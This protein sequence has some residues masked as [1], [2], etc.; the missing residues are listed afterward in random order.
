ME[1]HP[2]AV[3]KGV[4]LPGFAAPLA[5]VT[6]QRREA[7][8]AH[9]QGIAV[10]PDTA[11]SQPP[12]ASDIP[13]RSDDDNPVS[14]ACAACSGYCC[15]NGRDS[16]YLDAKDIGRILS[17]RPNLAHDELAAAYVAAVPDETYAG[18]CIF[19]AA[20]GCN[21]PREMRS[22]V[23]LTYFCWP[24]KDMFA[25]GTAAPDGK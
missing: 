9:L 11:A 4:E 3:W 10:G 25:A 1:R 7:L 21:L 2:V 18:S 5:K 24:L 15:R 12:A 6:P 17:S 16:A 23:C 14:A 13:A 8:T 19:H 20:H 22:H